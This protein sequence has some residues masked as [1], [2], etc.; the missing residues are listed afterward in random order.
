MPTVSTDPDSHRIY[1]FGEF[2]LDVDRGMLLRDGKEIRLRLQAY[3]VLRILVE[4]HGRLVSRETLLNQVWGRKA[5]SDDCLTHCL[6]DIRKALGD[7]S[8]TLI[9][10]VPRRGFILDVPVRRPGDAAG[11]RRRSR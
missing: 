1:A 9:R 4:Q 3:E 6:I 11:A 2:S 5:V 10:T 7:R 8:K